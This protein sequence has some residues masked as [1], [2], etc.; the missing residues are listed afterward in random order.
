M[1]AYFALMYCLAMTITRA[2]T[3]SSRARITRQGQITVPKAVRDSLGARAGD[4]L[5]FERVDD[6]FVVRHRPRADILAF[7][8]IARSAARRIPETAEGIDSVIARSMEA[9]AMASAGSRP[10]RRARPREP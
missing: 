9:A 10:A 4:F 1:D 5:E 2:T 3:K 8:G 7:A 6:G